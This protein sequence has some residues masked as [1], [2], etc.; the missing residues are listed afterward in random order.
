MRLVDKQRVC[1]TILGT[2]FRDTGSNLQAGIS[3]LGDA[4]TFSL[5]AGM[6]GSRD[7]VKT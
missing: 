7:D 5:G 4:L 3:A 6:T 2:S 1:M